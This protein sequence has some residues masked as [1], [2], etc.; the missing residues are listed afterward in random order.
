M[1][2]PEYRLWHALKHQQLGIKFRR[3]APKGAYILDFYCPQLRL[4]IEVDGESHAGSARDRIRDAWLDSQGYRVLR[5]WNHEVMQNLEG[6][7]A[8][9]NRELNGRF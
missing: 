6:V 9:I 3:Q 4:V 1:T 8:Q 2:E 7:L 5:F